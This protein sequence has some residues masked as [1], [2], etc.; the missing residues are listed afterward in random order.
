MEGGKRGGGGGGENL[1]WEHSLSLVLGSV[2]TAVTI[3]VLPS[4]ICM[5]MA[6][7]TSSSPE[8]VL[9]CCIRILHN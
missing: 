7:G 1:E 9:R 3:Y 6:L 2:L 4:E 8:L 5:R